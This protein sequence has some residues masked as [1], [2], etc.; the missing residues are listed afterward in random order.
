MLNYLRAECYKVFHRKYFWVTLLVLLGLESL[1]VGGW[2]F[3]NQRGSHVCFD[4]AVHTLSYVLVLGCYFTFLTG[5][6]VFA[7]QYKNG[8]LKNEVSFGLPRWRIYLGK[9]IA[10]LMT[11]VLLCFVILLYYVALCALVLP[12][13]GTTSNIVALVELGRW[14]LYALPIW[15]GAQATVC[16]CLFLIRGGTAAAITALALIAGS[17]PAVQ[18]IGLMFGR[19]SFGQFL[20]EAYAWLPTVMLERAPIYA[21]MGDWSYFGKLCLV[22][23][24]WFVGSTALGLWRFTRKEIN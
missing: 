10:Q 1:L 23:G 17:A 8:T 20:L 2:V 22:G 24:V 9:L 3:I 6:M 14:L 7:G 16:A 4:E 12:A 21:S 18:V 15:V 13:D 5:D 19:Y 11:A